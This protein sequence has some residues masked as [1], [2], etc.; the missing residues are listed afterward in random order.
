MAE[1]GMDVWVKVLRDKRVVEVDL[2]QVRD[3][4]ISLW[5][6]YDDSWWT[7]CIV[8]TFCFWA[9]SKKGGM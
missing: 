6:Y 1:E 9:V 8:E 4:S 5:Q 3:Y 2:A 7:I